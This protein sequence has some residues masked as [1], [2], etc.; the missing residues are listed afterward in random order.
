MFHKFMVYITIFLNTPQIKKFFMT[1]MS[2][3]DM[4]IDFRF[5][6]SKDQFNLFHW[7]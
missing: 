2:D 4:I 6:G 7:K 5:L 1:V 3:V